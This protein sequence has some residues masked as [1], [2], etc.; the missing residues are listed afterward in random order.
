P[1]SPPFWMPPAGNEPASITPPI[2]IETVFQPALNSS[3]TCSE[4]AVN[5]RSTATGRQ[6]TTTRTQRQY[7]Q[8]RPQRNGRVVNP[9][10][11]AENAGKSCKSAGCH[12]LHVQQS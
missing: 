5:L 11:A 10:S 2:Q 1:G 12:S 8:A 4:P 3:R 6:R 7:K 9:R